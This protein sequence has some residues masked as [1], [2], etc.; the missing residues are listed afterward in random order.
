MSTTYFI[1]AIFNAIA[2]GLLYAVDSR[3]WAINALLMVVVL[4]EGAVD[5]LKK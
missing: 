2:A 3:I 5:A 4:V 1:V